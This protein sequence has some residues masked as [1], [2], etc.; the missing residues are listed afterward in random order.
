MSPGASR[1]SFL[2]GMSAATAT[3]F[4]ATGRGSATSFSAGDTPFRLSVITDELTQDF[5]R[6][7]EIASKEFGLGFVELR[8]LWNKNIIALDEK[9]IAEVKRLLEHYRLQ[10]TD[11]ASPLFKTN[12]PGAPTSKY[13]PEKPQFGAD[14]PFEKQDEVLERSVVLAQVLKSDRIR[15]FDFWRLDDPQPFRSAMDEKLRE[16]AAR[17]APKNLIL[18]LE[19]EFACNT[20]TGAEAARTLQ[21]VQ[22]LNFKLNWD[23][24]NAA[25]RG[26]LAYPDGYQPI[27][28]DRIG[29][30]HCKDVRRK[31]DGSFEWEAMGR[32]IIDYVGQFRAML[33]D[34]YRGTVSLETHWSGAG[35]AEE[36]SRIS[37]AGMKE[38]LKKAG[39]L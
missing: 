12:W 38:Q 27:A 28:K 35:S 36:S 9:E 23:P 29:H 30:M 16:T 20:A 15:C 13:S 1:R 19:N 6:A 34:G 2:A 8:S 32:G 18:L 26:E 3:T 33:K 22:S 25:Y 39:A 24:G 31:A 5:G 21:A 17:L 14:F 37:M 11:I 4:F 7:L 10:V